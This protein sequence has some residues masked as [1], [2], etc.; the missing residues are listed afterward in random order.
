MMT[1]E[2]CH[3]MKAKAHDWWWLSWAS[4]NDGW[5]Y[6]CYVC[7]EVMKSSLEWAQT[8]ANFP[9]RSQTRWPPL[10]LY[11]HNICWRPL[12]FHLWHVG[13]W[14]YS[15]LQNSLWRPYNLPFVLVN[16]SFLFF[17]S[18]HS[19]SLKIKKCLQN[20]D[21]ASREKIN[22]D[23]SSITFNQN[24]LDITKTN[25]QE[26]LQVWNTSQTERNIGLPEIVG[27]NKT[28][29]FAFIIEKV[30][31]RMNWWIKKLSKVRKEVVDAFL[32]EQYTRREQI[33]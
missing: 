17:R 25:I 12:F 21:K 14:T 19:K 20:C 6:L 9:E 27:R 31:A 26:V 7:P 5:S 33:I 4:I 2:V 8:W 28:V 22:L 13:K 10:S 3:C 23:K 32:Y 29:F 1:F 15:R 11:F 16:D 24:V 30:R 18:C